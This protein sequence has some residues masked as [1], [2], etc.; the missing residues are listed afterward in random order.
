LNIY[1]G[2][3]LGGELG[4]PAPG[5]DWVKW[6]F[7]TPDSN[8][9]FVAA[10]QAHRDA[11]LKMNFSIGPDQGQGVPAKSDDEGLQWDLVSTA[12]KIY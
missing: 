4:G 2:I 1:L 9:L 5:A 12:V 11:G 3:T 8:K 6:G 10:L 7:G